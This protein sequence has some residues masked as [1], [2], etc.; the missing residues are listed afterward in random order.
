MELP[1][2]VRTSYGVRL[3]CLSTAVRTCYGLSL[4]TR[5]STIAAR[6]FLRHGT[7]YGRKNFLRQLHTGS[8]YGE[9]FLRHVSRDAE[10][11]TPRRGKFLRREFP[12][13][14]LLTSPSYGTT[15]YGKGFLRLGSRDAG[16]LPRG[17]TWTIHSLHIPMPKYF[18]HT[19]LYIRLYSMT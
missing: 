3:R 12:T 9:N 11:P 7:S 16:S 14:S 18:S 4:A 5:E 6:E 2:A 8:S 17:A 13:A 19:L 1:T 10:T 15:S